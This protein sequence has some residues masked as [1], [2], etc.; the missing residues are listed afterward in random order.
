MQILLIQ[1]IMN[2]LTFTNRKTFAKCYIGSKWQNE[3]FNIRLSDPKTKPLQN[4]Y[5][6][7]LT[8][9]LEPYGL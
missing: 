7:I 2:K 6:P 3:D 9:C 8:N 4:I 1:F 5:F